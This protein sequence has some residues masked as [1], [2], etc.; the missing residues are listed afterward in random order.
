MPVGLGDG[1]HDVVFDDPADERVRLGSVPPLVSA[2]EVCGNGSS[3]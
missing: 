3:F 2:V 1:L